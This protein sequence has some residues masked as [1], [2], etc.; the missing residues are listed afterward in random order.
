MK[1]KPRTMTPRTIVEPKTTVLPQQRSHQPGIEPKRHRG[2]IAT[3]IVSLVAA[4]AGVVMLWTGVFEGSDSSAPV[5]P[6][7]SSPAEPRQ[8]DGSD[9]RLNNRAEELLAQ[10]RAAIRESTAGSDRHLELRAPAGATDGSD[11]HLENL[12]AL[13]SR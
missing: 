11:A 3:G 2:A 13:A 9:M 5:A 10:Q 12:A 7:V 1:T 8:L 6:G 4:G